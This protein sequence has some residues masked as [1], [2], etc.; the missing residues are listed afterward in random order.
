[1]SRY[2]KILGVGL[3]SMLLWLPSAY[4]QRSKSQPAP[5]PSAPKPVVQYMVVV[6]L[7]AVPIGIICRS[8]RRST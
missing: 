2:A 4:A 6:V 5:T 1:M 3:F 8:S 7:L